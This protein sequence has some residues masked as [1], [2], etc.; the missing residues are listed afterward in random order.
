MYNLSLIFF[1]Y[2]PQVDSTDAEAAAHFKGEITRAL[3]NKRVYL[4]NFVH[5]LA[6]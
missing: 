5:I 3:K 2:A 1:L 6:N 4:N